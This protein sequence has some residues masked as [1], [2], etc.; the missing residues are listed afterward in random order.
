MSDTSSSSAP[1]PGPV[2][3]AK[4]PYQVILYVGANAPVVEDVRVVDLTPAETTAAA[5]LDKL[6][7]AELQP[8]D[9][10]SRVLFLT[11]PGSEFRDHA[12]M[13]YA[14]L[15][16]FAKRRVD[17][18]FDL[19]S[20]PLPLAEFDKALRRS[21]DAGR[22][23]EPVAQVQ[24]GGPARED[25][26]VVSIGA[27][28][29]T[30]QLVSAIRHARRVRFCPAEV[31]ELA[32]P[33]FAAVAALRARGES[34]KLPFLTDGTEPVEIDESGVVGICLNTL[35]R[36]A[37]ELRRSLRTGNRDAIADK[38]ELTDRQV[39]LL[40]AAEL[41]IEEVLRRLDA[42]SKMVETDPRPDTPEAEAGQKVLVELWHCP[43]PQNHTNNDATPSAR[44]SPMRGDALG[45]RCFRCLPEKVDALRLVM[46]ALELS[47]DEAADWL[48]AA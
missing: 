13:V 44:V 5:V 4:R 38:V 48:L 21:P 18:A 19:V 41:P 11:D 2:E 31:V 25:L 26:P 40:A 37:E 8:A 9:L 17:A 36:D 3:V 47:A 12:I 39:R 24:I 22:P 14:A 15:M 33:Q 28:G 32:L 34:D 6:R 16:G 29:F 7:A 43:R 1:K 10:R 42:K 27:G 30:P 46:W 20:A 35:R 45:F 23:E